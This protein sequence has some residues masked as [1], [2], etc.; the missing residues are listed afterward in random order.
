MP[1]SKTL[2]IS[3]K[4]DSYKQPLNLLNITSSNIAIGVN[5]NDFMETGLKERTDA[6]CLKELS[7]DLLSCLTEVFLKTTFAGCSDKFLIP[8]KHSSISALFNF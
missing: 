4:H 1:I 7:T 5:R 3:L 2:E 6:R 8:A